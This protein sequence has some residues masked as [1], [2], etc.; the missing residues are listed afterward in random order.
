MPGYGLRRMA[1]LDLGVAVTGDV[2]VGGDA[3]NKLAILDVRDCRVG[4]GAIFDEVFTGAFHLATC[5]V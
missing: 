4:G 2:A 5:V 1:Q 3:W